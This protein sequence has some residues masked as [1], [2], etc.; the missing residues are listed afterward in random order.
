[1]LTEQVLEMQVN[2]RLNSALSEGSKIVQT[3]GT[4]FGTYRTGDSSIQ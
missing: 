4:V 3:G 2:G 1:M